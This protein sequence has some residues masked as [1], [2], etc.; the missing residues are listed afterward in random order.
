M[1]IAEGGREIDCAI[2]DSQL[3]CAGGAHEVITI[4]LP[5][6]DSQGNAR[7][8]T[9]GRVLKWGFTLLSGRGNLEVCVSVRQTAEVPKAEPHVFGFGR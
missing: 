6:D 1:A 3:L 4:R 8:C 7:A 9:P 5:L 2:N